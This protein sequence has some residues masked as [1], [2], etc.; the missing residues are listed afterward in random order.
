M[1]EKVM[2]VAEKIKGFFGKLGKKT[3]IALSVA[4]A[5]LIVIAIVVTVTLN[6][7]PY[8][9]LFT[10]LAGQETASIVEYLREK[11]VTDYRVENN[12]TIWVPQEQENTLRAALLMEGYPKSGF[13]YSTYFE[14]V[15]ALSTESERNNAFLIALQERM[16]SV[17]RCFEGVKDAKVQ[18]VQGEDRRF[19]LDDSNMTEAT[20]SVLL[21]MYTG[22]K[23]T[24]E[25]TTAIRNL[26]ARAVQGLEIANVEIS[27]TMG[28]VY[29]VEDDSHVSADASAL[30]LQL[31]EQQSNKIRTDIMQVLTPLYGAEN[32]RVGVNCTVDVSRVVEDSVNYVEPE[33]WPQDGS[34]GGKGIIG[35][36]IY[37]N[38]IIQSGNADT[39]GVAGT[40]ANS[41]FSEY[42]E[43][44]QP[45]GDESTIS[46]SGQIDFKVGEKRAQV[47]RTAGVLSDV[48]VSVSINASQA[49]NVNE[50]SLLTHVARM[51][52]I[53]DEVAGEKI[54]ILVQ[55]FYEEPTLPIP[56]AINSIPTW[57]VVAAGGGILLF[58]LI[59]L[60]LLGIR[61][62]RKRRRLAEEQEAGVYIQQ[63]V[64]AQAATTGADVMSIQTEKSMELRKGI[65]QF[66]DDN[67]EIA[68]QMVKAWLKGGEEGG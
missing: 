17:I 22:R 27:D 55:P 34:T 16:E 41:E 5:A 39:G 13:S 56:D 37:D 18:I 42:V 12:D 4:L 25:Q 67:P 8:S 61:K 64:E 1:K 46:S 6:N 52:G 26:V 3:V 40:Q 57:V 7:K 11:G 62:R 20:A 51:A 47:I 36:T 9:V 59:L 35:S 19:L 15:S 65:R 32:V 66:A 31:E 24:G 54:S 23:L 58:L 53:G 63:Q 49:G 10:G 48:M 21:T 44:Y 14:K 50:A 33:G 38:K 60:I 45:E 68:A 43:N 2:T 28:N 30:K 29:S